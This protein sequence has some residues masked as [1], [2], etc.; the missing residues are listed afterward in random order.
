MKF[1]LKQ[2]CEGHPRKIVA[3][4]SG[5]TLSMHTRYEKRRRPGRTGKGCSFR[6]LFQLMFSGQQVALSSM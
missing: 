5:A 6:L 3:E 1:E 2:Y 4:F